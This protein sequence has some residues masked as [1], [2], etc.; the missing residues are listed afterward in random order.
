MYVCL[1]IC[2]HPRNN[3]TSCPCHVCQ[4]D[5]NLLTTENVLSNHFEKLL[6]IYVTPVWHQLTSASRLLIDDIKALK[7]MAQLVQNN[8]LVIT[9]ARLYPLI[10]NPYIN[11][12]FK[13][14]ML[15]YFSF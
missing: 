8:V 4:I 9:H 11:I 14:Y 7:L 10:V 12:Y 3:T 2:H 13:F 15:L 5:D 1:H 6:Q